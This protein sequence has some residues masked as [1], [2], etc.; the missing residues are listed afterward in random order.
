[1]SVAT[2]KRRGEAVTRASELAKE[3][4]TREEALD[5]DGSYASLNVQR[6]H[7]TGFL[8]LNVPWDAGGMGADLMTTLDVLRTLAHG[9]PSTALMLAM[10]TSVLSHLLIVPELIPAAERTSYESRRAWCW[11]QALEGAIFA[12]ANSEPGAGGDVRRS[13]ATVTAGPE[14]TLTGTKS[15]ASFGLNATFW[16]SAARDETGQL[17]YWLVRN[18][19]ATVSSGSQWDALGMRGSESIV[20]HFTGAPVVDVL[21]YRGL[22]DGVNHRHW[23]TLAFT[24]IIVGIAESLMTDLGELR[25]SLQRSDAV[26]LHLGIR[27]AR[28][29]LR[30]TAA[31]APAAPDREYQR[32]VRDCKTWTARTLARS[33]ATAFTSQTG[34]AYSRRS[35]LSRKLRDLLAGP[36][37]RPPMPTAWDEI[38]DELTSL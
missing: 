9:S 8:G 33:A 6:L 12:V 17:D 29:F 15:F 28:G 22:L 5:H 20:L 36:A 35:P 38:A 7:E 25:G 13:R 30:D 16:M 37:L 34:Q 11:Q 14:R 10:H 21:A 4:A 1:M 3:F 26:E 18:D 31:A 2:V 23:S 24:A 27:A 32:L 19:S